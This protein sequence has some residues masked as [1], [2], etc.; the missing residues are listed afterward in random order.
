M[1]KPSMTEAVSEY[2]RNA[3]GIDAEPTS[4]CAESV[5]AEARSFTPP[6]LELV[7]TMP[8]SLPCVALKSFTRSSNACCCV[9]L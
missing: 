5:T 2:D 4:P 6:W 1:P 3:S 8:R 9:P 7:T